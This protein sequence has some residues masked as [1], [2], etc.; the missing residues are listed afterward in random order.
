MLSDGLERCGLLVD[1]CDAFISCLDSHSDGTHSLQRI[2]CWVSDLMLHFSKSDEETNSSTSCMAWE[3]HRCC[4]KTIEV[5]NK[6]GQVYFV[7]VIFCTSGQGSVCLS[8][9]CYWM[10]SRWSGDDPP[11]LW[12]PALVAMSL[13]KTYS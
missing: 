5:V 13:C 7:M 9:S 2:Y 3:W 11:L 8:F 4:Q 1:Y 10:W 6:P 12:S